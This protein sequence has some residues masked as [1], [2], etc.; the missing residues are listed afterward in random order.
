VHGL[1]A[2]TDAGTWLFEGA[3]TMAVLAVAALTGLRVSQ[4]RRPAGSRRPV[5]LTASS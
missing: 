2:G 1:T 5:R 4:S 3:A